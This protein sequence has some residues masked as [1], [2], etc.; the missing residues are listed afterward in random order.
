MRKIWANQLLPKAFK[1]NQNP[2]NR[3]IWSHW[4]QPIQCVSQHSLNKALLDLESDNTIYRFQRSM[5]HQSRQ[6]IVQDLYSQI[7]QSNHTIQVYWKQAFGWSF[8]N[9]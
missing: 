8:Y 4:M 9:R 3:P 7:G 2:K 6:F 1:V 5:S